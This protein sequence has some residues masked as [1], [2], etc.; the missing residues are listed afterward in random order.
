MHHRIADLGSPGR[1][2][3]MPDA[4]SVIPVRRR[5]GR[6]VRPNMSRRCCIALNTGQEMSTNKQ[7]GY[8]I[9][10]A[11]T[12]RGRRSVYVEG[13]HGTA[14]DSF[15]APAGS[16]ELC[17]CA[18][19]SPNEAADGHDWRRTNA[20]PTPKCLV[21]W[22]CTCSRPRPRPHPRLRRRR[23]TLALTCKSHSNCET[24]HSGR[25]LHLGASLRRAMLR[26]ALITRLGSLTTLLCSPPAQSHPLSPKP[27]FSLVAVPSP[28]PALACPRLPSSPP[29]APATHTNPL[30]C[31]TAAS[32]LLALLDM[33]C[34]LAGH[35][36]SPWQP[37]TPVGPQP[38]RVNFLLISGT[39]VNP[40]RPLT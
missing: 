11:G 7:H 37:C 16:H 38:T 33:P 21:G 20:P 34:R 36:P 19:T 18:W 5:V 14:V 29:R 31:C 12:G 35:T 24:R 25:F 17:A 32:P 40:N 27:L 3:N 23:R 39:H 9:N 4:S 6:R 15:E 26:G 22:T 10:G 1:Q 8:S 13:L 28:K 30:G 2:T